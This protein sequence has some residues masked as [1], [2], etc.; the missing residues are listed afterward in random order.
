MT[1]TFMEAIDRHLA[2]VETLGEGHP[3]TMR[4]ML[5]AMEL[6]PDEIKQQISDKA[7]EL[8]LLP[9]AMGYLEDGTPMYRL[10]DIAEKTGASIEEAEATLKELMAERE[11]L[12]LSNEVMLADD[13]RIH[14]RQ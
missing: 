13:K 4:A 5:L 6:A 9:D 1:D 10:N 8:D 7:R 2:L 14:R 11:A 3:D 12:G